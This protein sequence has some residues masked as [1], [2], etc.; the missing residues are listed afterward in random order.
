MAPR[1]IVAPFRGT[2]IFFAAT[3]ELNDAHPP[4]PAR[5]RAPR[6]GLCPG[7]NSPHAPPLTRAPPLA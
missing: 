6:A 4:V 5:D 7:L 2:P 1:T 3:I